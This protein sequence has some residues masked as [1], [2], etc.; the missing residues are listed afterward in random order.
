MKKILKNKKIKKQ[1]TWF[2]L[3]K[4]EKTKKFCKEK[5]N[6]RILAHYCQIDNLN[7]VSNKGFLNYIGGTW[8]FIWHPIELKTSKD[9]TE[10]WRFLVR[11][12]LGHCFKYLLIKYLIKYF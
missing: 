6:K 2:C 9:L 8:G 1:K 5:K 4:N 3:L 10:R 11:V 12:V 7:S